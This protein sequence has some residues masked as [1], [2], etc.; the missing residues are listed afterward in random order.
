MSLLGDRTWWLPRWLD[1]LPPDLDVESETLTKM[2]DAQAVPGGDDGDPS[3]ARA[4][5]RL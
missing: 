2:L 4:G 5:G 1:R 3:D